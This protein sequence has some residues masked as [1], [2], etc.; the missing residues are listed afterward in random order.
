MKNEARTGQPSHDLVE[1][2][3]S[4]RF[5]DMLSDLAG[6]DESSLRRVVDNL[7]NGSLPASLEIWSDSESHRAT[8]IWMRD[9]LRQELTL[10]EVKALLRDPVGELSSWITSTNGVGYVYH[11]II[12]RGVDSVSALRLAATPSVI[13]A[14]IS[15]LALVALYWLA[16]G[17]LENAKP[18]MITNDLHD[19]EYAVLGSLSVELLS[20]DKRLQAITRAVKLSQLSRQSWVKDQLGADEYKRLIASPAKTVSRGNLGSVEDKK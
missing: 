2:G 17:G 14:F 3:A 7:E 12:A 19:I 5:C 10:R 1:R 15:S 6:G 9:L 11:A 13:G 18:E 8:I 20:S 16:F 4:A